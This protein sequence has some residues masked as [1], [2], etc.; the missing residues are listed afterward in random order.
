MANNL[1]VSVL[2]CAKEEY[3]NQ[4]KHYL[5]PLIQEG[6]Q[7]IYEDAVL[8]D[9]EGNALKQFQIFLKEIPKW[10]QTILDQET[11]RIKEKCE[12][13]MDLVTAIFVSHVKILASVRLG[14][15]HSNIR[16]KVPTSEIFIHSIYVGGAERFYYDPYPFEDVCQR[17]N[18]EK[19]RDTVDDVIEETISSMIPIQSILQEYLSTA[20]QDHTKPEPPPDPLPE[21]PFDRQFTANDVGGGVDD[22][23]G[24]SAS[25]FSSS[26]DAKT[27]GLNSSGSGPVFPIGDKPPFADKIGNNENVV[28][29][30]ETLE[31]TAGGSDGGDNRSI[32]NAFS[33]E[34]DQASMSSVPTPTFDDKPLDPPPADPILDSKPSESSSS[35]SDPISDPLADLPKIDDSTSGAL[36]NLFDIP[37][38]SDDPLKMDDNKPSSSSATSSGTSS[39]DD[40][41]GFGSMDDLSGGTSSDSPKEK[42]FSFSFFDN[43]SNN[44]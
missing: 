32:G 40:P 19:I 5:T 31:A 2:V 4:L 12:F 21:A 13:L 22:I 29:L 3:T 25:D 17:K 16:I 44:I 39:G 30:G 38:S 14:G 1:N 27:I 20:F 36:D 7:S 28:D 11:K 35:S 42:D 18:V 15:N 37:S 10:N 41:F 23:F 26:T 43:D 8:N 9:E 33:S 34:E 6:F 24:P